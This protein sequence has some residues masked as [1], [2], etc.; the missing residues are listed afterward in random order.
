MMMISLGCSANV[1]HN[2]AKIRETTSRVG[3]KKPPILVIRF[4]PQLNVLQLS[5]TGN[6]LRK[7]KLN[8]TSRIHLRC[9]ASYKLDYLFH[10][11]RLY[12]PQL[13]PH[14]SIPFDVQNFSFSFLFS[15]SSISCRPSLTKLTRF[16]NSNYAILAPA[17]HLNSTEIRTTQASSYSLEVN[18]FHHASI[19]AVISRLS[20][21]FWV[22][23]AKFIAR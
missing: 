6:K 7:A 8:V 15:T 22:I 5:V 13:A 23:T 10:T 12:R 3:G 1:M 19:E 18:V 2:P 9:I 20:A 14:N 16:T 4:N 17:P 11:K 21:C